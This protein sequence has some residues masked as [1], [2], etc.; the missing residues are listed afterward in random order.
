M[1][2][3]PRG[4]LVLVLTTTAITVA[5]CGGSSK[6]PSGAPAG[7]RAGT[8]TS[9]PAALQPSTKVASAAYRAFAERGLAQIPGV[10]TAAIPKIISCVVQKEL[11]QGITT[12]GA[13]NSHRSQVRTD[14]VDCA[15]TAG[16]H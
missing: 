13:V 5:G 2:G 6:S 15:R 4:W 1:T 12:V 3:V 14:G 9:V 10:P 7:S 11:A 16:L 8:A